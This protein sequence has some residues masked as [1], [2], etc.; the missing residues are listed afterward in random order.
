V[1]PFLVACHAPADRAGRAE[2]ETGLP[3][4]DGSGS[5]EAWVLAD[6]EGELN[7]L[8]DHGDVDPKQVARTFEEYLSHG[9]ET[10]PGSDELRLEMGDFCTAESGYQ[11][12]G[13]GWVDPGYDVSQHTG[14]T[15]VSDYQMLDDEGRAFVGGGGM[16]EMLGQPD[17]GVLD[18]EINALGTYD[19]EQAE[20]GFLAERWSAAMYIIGQVAEGGLS[21]FYVTG[22]FSLG[23]HQYSL[24]PIQWTEDAASCPGRV[25]GSLA[26]RDAAG[27]WYDWMLG[28]DC[29]ECGDVTGPGG[30]DLG[31]LCY[32]LS[33]YMSNFFTRVAP[34]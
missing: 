24:G 2:G 8:V 29:D 27:S 3:T 15:F 17:G 28:D 6:I 1:I 19:D 18:F 25:T 11:Y 7:Y 10:C 31:E 14:W 12:Q 32:D 16:Y 26:V 21:Y 13:I 30:E 4:F 9:D 5:A 33:T 20:S 34:L 23:E 22:G